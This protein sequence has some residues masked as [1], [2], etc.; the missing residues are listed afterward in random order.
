MNQEYR[1]H[2]NYWHG[3]SELILRKT[4]RLQDLDRKLGKRCEGQS[5]E[6]A[7]RH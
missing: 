7:T 1:F 6:N 4:F 3:C 5:V 2:E